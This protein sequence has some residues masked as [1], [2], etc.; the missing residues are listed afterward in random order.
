MKKSHIALLVLIAIMIVGILMYGVDFSTYSTITSAQKNPGKFVHIIARLDTA[1][2]I[3]YDPIKNPNFLSFYAIDSLG[4]RTKVVYHKEKPT[5]IEKSERLV[6]KG[7]MEKEFFDC[8]DILLKCPSKY[9]DNKKNLQNNMM[10]I[11]ST[12]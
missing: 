12:K 3:E 5:D 6:L 8:S 7:K 10:A 9:K 2:P 11:D 4:G 1:S